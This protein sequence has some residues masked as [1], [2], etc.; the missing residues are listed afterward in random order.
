MT[1][2]AARGALALPPR[3]I[4]GIEIIPALPPSVQAALAAVP[5]WMA[6]Q[7]KALALY[8]RPVWREAGLSGSAFSQAGPLGELHDASLPGAAE[9]ALFGFF[10]WPPALRAA[11]RAALP[12]LV[13]R[14]LGLLFGAEAARPREMII[15]DWAT[16]PFT[17]TEA[18]HAN[19]NV[20]PD[21]RP[22]ALPA[23]W[24][25]RITLAG[26]EIA[27]EFGGYLEGALAAAEAAVIA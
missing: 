19:G 5:G 3:L 20:H 22:I 13:A 6:G 2:H 24:S 25:E 10:S 12:E 11:R 16:E 26:S 4:G 17:A 1:L 8:D 7:A 23:P 21:Y 14:Q 15:Q 9:A 18:D 27:P